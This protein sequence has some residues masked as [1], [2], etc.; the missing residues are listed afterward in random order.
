M[1]DLIVEIKPKY[2]EFNRVLKLEILQ[3][4]KTRWFEVADIS[5]KLKSDSDFQTLKNVFNYT[6][7]NVDYQQDTKNEIVRS[8][9]HIL[10]GYNKGIGDCKS[11]S[12]LT[13]SLLL[14]LN[15][16]S[17][18]KFVGYGEAGRKGVVNHVYAMSYENDDFVIMDSTIK[19]FNVCVGI[20]TRKEIYQFINN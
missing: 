15:L 2:S 8:P 14:C 10:F 20:E 19:Q 18:I 17:F 5:K 3:K 16:P 7:Q 11:H 4:I 13:C 9:S 12:I 1:R 6:L